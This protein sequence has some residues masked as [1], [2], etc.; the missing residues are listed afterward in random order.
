MSQFSQ[1]LETTVL[2]FHSD[3]S[4]GVHWE[5]FHRQGMRSLEVQLPPGIL[6]KETVASDTGLFHKGPPLSFSF[7]LYKLNMRKSLTTP[8]LSTGHQESM[9]LFPYQPSRAEGKWCLNTSRAVSL[10]F[11][12]HTHCVYLWGHAA[13][14]IDRLHFLLTAVPFLWIQRGHPV[15]WFCH[16]AFCLLLGL[17]CPTI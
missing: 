4:W 9:P 1:W 16:H 17:V 11:G 7:L 2:M 14:F 5:W 6:W 8:R 15:S 10:V 3:P 13:A 12:V